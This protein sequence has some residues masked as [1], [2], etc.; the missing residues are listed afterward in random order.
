MAF[1][2]PEMSL[3][4]ERVRSVGVAIGASRLR[5]SSDLFVE[6]DFFIRQSLVKRRATSAPA[7]NSTPWDQHCH[8]S[9]MLLFESSL[10][11]T[12]RRS[13]LDCYRDSPGIF[14]DA[15]V[16]SPCSLG[17]SLTARKVVRPDSDL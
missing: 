5:S 8:V 15:G 2:A 17:R 4:A 1:I 14:C 16:T 3:L 7:L 12:A 13:R 9:F 6:F 11:M 10:R